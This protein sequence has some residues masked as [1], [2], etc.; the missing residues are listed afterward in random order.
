VSSKTVIERIISFL[1]GFSWALVFIFAFVMFSL[2]EAH[3]SV[4]VS[5]F[6]A[7]IGGCLGLF[8]V[9]FLEL[10]ILQFK[11]YEELQKQTQILSKL[12]NS[13]SN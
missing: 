5:I 6:A 7:I 2:F 4:V 1:L 11:K 8:F 13:D 3:F 9:L 12:Q 10:S